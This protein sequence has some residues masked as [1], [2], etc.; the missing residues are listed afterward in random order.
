MLTRK[1][2]LE[3]FINSKK[4]SAVITKVILASIAIGGF[5]TVAAIVPNMVSL[6]GRRG[7]FNSKKTY[8]AFSGLKRCGF[9]ETI[10]EKD[11]KEVVRIT[12]K[13]ETR[14]KEFELDGLVIRR[15]W[16]WDRKWRMLIFDIPNRRR[17]AREALRNKIK[18][19][20]FYQLQKSVWVYPYSCHEEIMFVANFFEILPFVEILE[21]KIILNEGK[22]KKFFGL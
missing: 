18:E 2:R 10:R 13:G 15:P 7:R 17:N 21:S 19:L 12:A 11:G 3:N 20:G 16:R 1:E 8:N 22:V 9:I 4:P 5:V 6:L 14:I